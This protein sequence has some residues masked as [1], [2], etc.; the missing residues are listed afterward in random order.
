MSLAFSQLIAIFASF[1]LGAVP[2]GLILGWIGQP[3]ACDRHPV[4]KA[5][6]S[7]RASSAWQELE[8]V[9]VARPTGVGRA[10]ATY[11]LPIEGRDEW[12]T[13]ARRLA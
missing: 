2:V 10:L 7:P 11:E 6:R 5:I 4:R 13:A 1:A 8:Q 3:D 12:L 9:F